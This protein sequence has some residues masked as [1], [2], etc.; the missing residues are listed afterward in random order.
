MT[1]WRLARNI[2]SVKEKPSCRCD[3]YC[4]SKESNQKWEISFYFM[5]KK[6]LAGS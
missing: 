6:F 4:Y 5:L 3:Y 2:Y 1:V